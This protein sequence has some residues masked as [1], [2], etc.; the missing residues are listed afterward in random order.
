MEV[1]GT[2]PTLEQK[3]ESEITK[4]SKNNPQTGTMEHQQLIK[5][6]KD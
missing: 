2:N 6:L 3:I 1:V 5:Y 4:I